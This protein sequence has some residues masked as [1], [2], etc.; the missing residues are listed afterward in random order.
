MKEVFE[1]LQALDDHDD[2]VFFCTLIDEVSLEGGLQLREENARTELL[3]SE[4]PL[5]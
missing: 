5:V 3:R 1:V 4:E 2:V